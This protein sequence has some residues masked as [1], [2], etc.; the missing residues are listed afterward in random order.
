MHWSYMFQHIFMD[1]R[2]SCNIY[3]ISNTIYTRTLEWL[4]PTGEAIG[5]RWWRHLLSTLAILL[6]TT[7]YNVLFMITW[8][9]IYANFTKH[10][11]CIVI[12]YFTPSEYQSCHMLLLCM[13]TIEGFYALFL[14][15][16]THFHGLMILV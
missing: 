15:V 16:S 3:V 2:Y 13:L 11:C 9:A 5:G 8:I 6:A 1:L 7:Y 10:L 4:P 14:N 12:S